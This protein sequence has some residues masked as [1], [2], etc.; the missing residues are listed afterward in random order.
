MMNLEPMK[1]MRIENAQTNRQLVTTVE[2]Y[3]KIS[4]K[5]YLVIWMAGFIS[6]S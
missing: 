6:F 5:L 3:I 2:A 4:V 1:E